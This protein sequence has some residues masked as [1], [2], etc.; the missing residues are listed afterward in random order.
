MTEG[1][2]TAYGDELLTGWA[3]ATWS[4]STVHHPGTPADLAELLAAADPRGTIAR[5]LG[6]AYGDAAQRAGGTVIQVDRLGGTA[7]VDAAGLVTAP[8]S[9]SIGDLLRGL[10]PQGWFVPVTPGT[11]YVTL[12]GALAADVHGKN[13][14][15][16][17]S[18]SQHV[19]SIRLVTPALGEVVVG[20]DQ[21]PELFWATAGGMGLTGVIT[22]VVFQAIPVESGDMLVDT[23][24]TADLDETMAVLLETDGPFRY[25]V[26]WLDVMATGS[27]LGRGIVT[28]GDHAPRSRATP[29]GPGEGAVPAPPAPPWLMNR[30]SIRAFCELWYRKAPRRREG[31]RQSAGMFFYPLD[32]VQHWNRL[33][34]RPGFLQWQTVLP[35]G[36]EALLRSHIERL[37]DH[38]VPS[39]LNV[40]KRFGPE[41]PGP[42]SFPEAGWTLCIDTPAGG[43]FPAELFDRM[44]REVAGAGG[45]IYLAK[46]ARMDPALLPV[47]YPRL[48]E[49][50][51]VVHR[52]DPDGVLASDLSVRLN[53]RG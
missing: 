34:G 42:L 1:I 51:G 15:H 19:R 30:L 18:I 14:H 50:R 36:Q 28:A 20:P 22:E 43:G 27:S 6:R 21:D 9:V 12:A 3:R 5:G 32:L 48:D 41:A 38:A 24:R 7:H 49:W 53:L 29:A 8:A 16:D 31:E 23:W 52:A 39:F 2:N 13:H 10:I 26:G 46:D 44:D 37:A 40:L 47:M 33:Y 45:R 25:T 4:R 11:Q 17:G 35:D